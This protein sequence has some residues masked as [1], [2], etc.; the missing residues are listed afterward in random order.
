MSKDCL[1]KYISLDMHRR[2][3]YWL[4]GKGKGKA[5]PLQA[6]TDPEGTR[7]VKIPDFMTVGKFIFV[8]PNSCLIICKVTTAT[9]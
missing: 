4:K 9:G 8:Y 6:R 7:K 5:I 1:N 3:S 2:L